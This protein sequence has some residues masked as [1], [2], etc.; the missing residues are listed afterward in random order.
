MVRGVVKVEIKWDN[1][2]WTDETAR[3]KHI[4]IRRGRDSELDAV[5][6]GACT[7]TLVD[8][9]G[10]YN[11]LNSASALYGYTNKVRP[12]RIT[13]LYNAVTYNLYY[14]YTRR[15]VSNQARNVQQATIQCLDFF[16]QLDKIKPTIASSSTTTG[17]A[18]AAILTAAGYSGTTDLDTG[19]SITF[20]SDGTVTALQLIANLLTTERGMFYIA[21]NGYPTYEDRYALNRS[22]RTSVQSTITGTMRGIAPGWDVESVRNRVTVTR[23]GGTA[24]TASDS[25]SITDYGTRDYDAISSGYLS[26]DNVAASLASYLVKRRKDGIAPI[27]TLELTNKADAPY[28]ALLAR[29]LLDRVSV[30]ETLGGTSFDGHIQSISREIDAPS[31]THFGRWGILQ[32]D[33]KQPFLIGSSG[34]GGPDVITY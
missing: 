24:Q 2:S 34:I 12:V 17:A 15:V 23:T 7:L 1:A 28:T 16:A 18:I 22:P 3:V 29:D 8:T 21:G 14:G 11:P 27:R 20:S 33:T 19:D 9:D 30:T 4:S 32:R 26:T 25:T 13:E 6:A 10:R 5:M 31:A